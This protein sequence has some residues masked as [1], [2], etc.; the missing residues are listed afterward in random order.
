[1]R[2]MNAPDTVTVWLDDFGRPTRL[3]WRGDRYRVT[4]T[5]TLREDLVLGIMHPPRIDGWRFQGTR[6]DGQSRV[7]DVRHDEARQEWELLAVYD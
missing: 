6:D 2:L 5:P 4:D 7:F 3:V 1:M